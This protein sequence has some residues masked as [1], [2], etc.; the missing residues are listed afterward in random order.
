MGTTARGMHQGGSNRRR[1]AGVRYSPPSSRCPRASSRGRADGARRHPP[2]PARPRA[3]RR[4]LG[5]SSPAPWQAY[6]AGGAVDVVAATAAPSCTVVVARRHAE[7]V[8]RSGAPARASRVVDRPGL[9]AVSV[10][11]PGRRGGRRCRSWR[12]TRTP[13]GPA[14]AG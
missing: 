9:Y 13:G 4:G 12:T 11:A 1:L 3:R 5:C 8:P 10:T 6:R 14:A 2:R 7:T